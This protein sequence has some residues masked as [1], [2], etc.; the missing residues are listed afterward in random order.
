MNHFLSQLIL[1]VFASLK[2][3]ELFHPLQWLTPNFSLQY[4]P[5]V[6]WIREMFIKKKKIYIFKQILFV[7]TLGNVQRTVWRIC[8]LMLGS[9]KVNAESQR[10]R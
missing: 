2:F 6:T 1:Y 5:S 3:T 4:H 10:M 9:K 7:S 8:I